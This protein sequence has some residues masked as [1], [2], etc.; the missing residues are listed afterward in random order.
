MN[1]ENS[2]YQSERSSS[3]WIYSDF[4]F[5]WNFVYVFTAIYHILLQ[6]DMD[7]CDDCRRVIC[8]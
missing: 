2:I 8:E 4:P 6:V 5:D 7:L 1:E 3:A